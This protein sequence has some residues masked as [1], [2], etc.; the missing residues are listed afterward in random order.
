M[1]APRLMEVSSAGVRA[2]L[3]LEM[4][5]FGLQGKVSMYIESSNK[6]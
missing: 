6:K 3:K 5:W 1:K 2:L 4:W